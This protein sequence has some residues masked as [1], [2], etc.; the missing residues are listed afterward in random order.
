M[1]IITSHQCR[2]ARSLLSMSEYD[3][4]EMANLD[5]AT[6]LA[7]EDKNNQQLVSIRNV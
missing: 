5:V 1:Q 7:I 2:K 6:V 4:A 3:L